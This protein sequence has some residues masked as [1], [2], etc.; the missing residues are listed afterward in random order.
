M[1]LLRNSK[2]KKTAFELEVE[3]EALRAQTRAWASITSFAA[4][5][6]VSLRMVSPSLRLRNV[7]LCLCVM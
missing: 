7:S 2:T 6:H 4:L 3:L 5:P 1:D